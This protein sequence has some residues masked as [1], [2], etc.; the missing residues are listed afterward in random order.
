MPNAGEKFVRL[1]EDD[2]DEAPVQDT[3]KPKGVRGRG[4]AWLAKN[5]LPLFLVLLALFGLC[6]IIFGMF[7]P[8]ETQARSDFRA[9]CEHVK[10]RFCLPD[11]S[12][13]GMTQ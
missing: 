7:Q 10:I 11:P 5:W 6:C 9:T 12:W 13:Q 4:K 1:G 3:Q 8:C 2:A